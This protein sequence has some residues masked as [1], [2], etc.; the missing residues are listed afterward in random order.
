M[1]Q[2]QGW[3]MHDVVHAWIGFAAGIYGLGVNYRSN[4]GGIRSATRWRE[5]LFQS[6]G[7]EFQFLANCM[8]EFLFL[9]SWEYDDGSFLCGWIILS[10]DL[11]WL[12][13]CHWLQYKSLLLPCIVCNFDSRKIHCFCC[14][15]V[16]PVLVLALT[17]TGRV[18]LQNAVVREFTCSGG[19][20]QSHFW[21]VS[22]SGTTTHWCWWRSSSSQSL[23]VDRIASFLHCI[24]RNGYI[25]RHYVD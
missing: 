25:N 19:R 3:S 22:T 21:G 14:H 24:E 23:V 16:V 18:G 17:S 4:R 20:R 10:L 1:S 13:G 2:T 6:I 11:L 7:W 9:N 5:F 8:R 15:Q 12:L